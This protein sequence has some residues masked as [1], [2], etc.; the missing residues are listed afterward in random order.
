GKILIGAPLDGSGGSEA[1]AA[2]LFD[3]AS[4]DFRRLQKDQPAAGDLFGT[5][6]A[7]LGPYLAVGAPGDDTGAPDAGAVYLFD[8]AGRLLQ[9]FRNP[10]PDPGDRFGF[11]LAFFSQVHLAPAG[12]GPD[13]VTTGGLAVGAP[14]DDRGAPDAGI[15][16]VYVY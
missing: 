5:S 15:A 9:A 8:Q 14:G 13:I 16:Y 11:S 1:G 12:R 7:A 3:P 10:S 4:G 2:Y 6:V